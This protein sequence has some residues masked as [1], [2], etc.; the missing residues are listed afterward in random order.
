MYLSIPIQLQI[1]EENTT[2]QHYIICETR[3]SVGSMILDDLSEYSAGMAPPV[4][5][6]DL[7]RPTQTEENTDSAAQT[8]IEVKKLC[9]RM[10]ISLQPSNGR[11]LCFQSSLLA[12]HMGL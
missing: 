6:A 5:Q 2:A 3:Y 8:E 1:A 12:V 7:Q 4:L 9:Q 10:N 11:A